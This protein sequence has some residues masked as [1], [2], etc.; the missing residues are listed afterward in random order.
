MIRRLLLIGAGLKRC[1]SPRRIGHRFRPSPSPAGNAGPTAFLPIRGWQS[2]G[3]QL[4]EG[5]FCDHPRSREWLYTP[6]EYHGAG[7][8]CVLPR[9]SFYPL[10]NP[11][12]YERTHSVP[13]AAC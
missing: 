13:R 4:N 12:G 10:S 8:P 5:D 7:R 1:S 2:I 9:W 3:V 11:G 6:G